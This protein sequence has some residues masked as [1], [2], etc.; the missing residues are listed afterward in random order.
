M[1]PRSI[2][3]LGSLQ[4]AVLELVWDAGE[5]TVADVRSRLRSRRKPAYTTVLSVMQK[6]EKLGLLRHRADGRAYVYRAVRSRRAAG[7][8]SLRRFMKSVFAGDPLLMFEHL[9]EAGDLSDA[10]LAEL[11]RLIDARRRKGA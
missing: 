11:R 3:N 10:E 4:R 8:D 6:L 9:L 2:E 1:P 7:I 5:A